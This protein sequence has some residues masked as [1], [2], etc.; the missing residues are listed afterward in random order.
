MPPVLAEN[1]RALQRD[2]SA[3]RNICILAHV[4][5]GKTTLADSLVASNGIISQ[6]LAGK[7]RYLDSR[8][9]EQQR[10]ITMKSSAISLCHA[11]DDGRNFLVNLIDSP[12]HVD[13]SSEVSTA[14]RLCDGA[15]IVVDAVEG[16]QPQTKVVLQQAW[17]EG[18]R[19]VLVVNKLDRLIVEMKLTPTD[20]YLHI[21]SVLEQVN[22]VIGELF[23][24]GVME[25]AADGA[26][27]D[28]A[29]DKHKQQR[30]Q[31]GGDA[32]EEYFDWSTGLDEADDSGLYF[33]PD[34]GNVVFA[35]AVDGW[36]FSLATFAKIYSD[37]LGFNVKVLQKTLWGDY[38]I[39]AK[40]KK[41]MKGALAKAKKPL[42]VQMILEN[43]WSVY[44]CVVVRKDKERLASIVSALRLK[45]SA[46]D[47]RSTDAR[48]QLAAVFSQWLPLAAAVLDAVCKKLPSPRD[49]GA[50]RTERLM[51]SRTRRFSALPPETRQLKPAFL[52][53]SSSD[54]AEVIVFISKM[55]PVSKKTLPEFRPKPIT[56]EEMAARREAARARLKDKRREEGEALAAE[57]QLAGMRLGAEGKEAAAAA[58]AD[59]EAA[60]E[61]DDTAFVAFARV[62][63]GTVRPGQTLYV[64]GPKYDPSAALER[65]R[66]GEE[67]CSEDAT[68]REPGK[69]AGHHI[70][71]A[72]VKSVYLLLGRELEALDEAP[73]GSIVGLGGLENFVL[74]SATLSSSFACPA[75]VEIASSAVPIMRVAVEPLLSTDMSRLVHGLHLLN[76]ADAHVQVLLTD[77]GEHVLVTA[78]EVHLERCLRDLRETYARVDVAASEPIVPFRETV[79]APPRKDMVNEE[80]NDENKRDGGKQDVDEEETKKIIEIQTPNKHCIVRLLAVPLPSEA[81]LLLEDNAELLKAIHAATA[82]PTADA[83][84]TLSQKTLDAK[85]ELRNKLE[86]HLSASAELRELEVGVGDVWS[87]GPR[88]CGPNILFNKIANYHRSCRMFC[89]SGSADAAA[90]ADARDELDSSFVSGFQLCTVGG[91]L[92]EEPLMGVGFVVLDWRLSGAPSDADAGAD[93]Y[94]PISGQIVSAVKDGCRRAFQARP[95]RLMA[96]MYSCDIQVKAEVLGRMYAVLGK[97]HGQIVREAMIEGSSTFTV[98]AHLPVVESFDFANEIR[99]QTSG[100]AM[101]QLVFSHWGLIDVDPFWVPKTS[102][103]ILHFGDKADS[104]NQARRYVNDVRKKK[105]LAIDEKIVEFAEKQRTLTKNK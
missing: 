91:P 33:S 68:V 41:I 50:D 6:R 43:I 5:H 70:M 44:E 103:E 10:G 36:A 74:K 80:F 30:K 2:V 61:G 83:A 8:A 26:A 96:A 76:Q 57:D 58:A 59:E 51:C 42:F 65:V 98:T 63:S 12:G 93:V 54:E 88:R 94:G 13:F 16:V 49:L 23:A 64:L 60:A 7:L 89:G 37:K 4:D 47:L 69:A 90:A 21:R 105:G 86:K 62:Y 25:S 77:K 14:V 72:T 101:P 99:K 52:A 53:C 73:A 20:A 55:F 67:L 56:A 92:C 102:E 38:F 11:A 100:L 22:A 32:S 15:L 27:A 1:L 3:I 40:A 85:K 75:F 48:Q 95:Q 78:G 29:E 17:R 82:A 84:A 87:V 34:D 19:P 39:N 79:V 31:A 24:S 97:R 18:I 45:V 104:E 46:R 28:D 35:S 81:A 9:D 66:N 71:R